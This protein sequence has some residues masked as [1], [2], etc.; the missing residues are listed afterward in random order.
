MNFIRCGVTKLPVAERAAYF[1][2]Q[3]D[4]PMA[5]LLPGSSL[6][7]AKV[8]R[9]VCSTLTRSTRV[10]AKLAF[11]LRGSAR[12]GPI[13]GYQAVQQRHRAQVAYTISKTYEWVNQ[14]N[15]QDTNLGDLLSSG[16]EK[17][18]IEFDTP[19]NLSVVFSYELPFGKGKQ[20]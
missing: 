17:R 10:S 4:N 3:V 13:Q 2:A 18:L 7:G 11:P 15:V 6:N 14:M 16:L 5:G 19:Q 9:Q 20:S 8:P 12:S 1:T